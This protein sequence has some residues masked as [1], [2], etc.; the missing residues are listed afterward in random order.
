MIRHAATVLVLRPGADGREVYMVRRS[1]KSPF[2]PST[3]VF[4]GGRVDPEDGAIDQDPS[5]ERAARRECEEEARLRLGPDRTL[6]WFD[7]WLTPS[8]ESRRRYLARFF[9]TELSVGE[10]TEA[11]ADG[12]ETHEGRWA[13]AAEHLAAWETEEVDLPPPT[14]AMLL[15]LREAERHGLPAMLDVDPRALI[16]PKVI[17]ADGRLTILMPHDPDYAV[18]PGE[19]AP[20]P[21]R[22]HGLP[23]R[24]V[25]DGQRWR[26]C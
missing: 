19:A 13:T 10:G 25:R 2:M 9:M 1:A 4:P 26:P 20:A 22:V 14:L 18:A 3:L 8:A 16:L 12:V 7:T 6:R 23:S 5:W 11:Q 21:A 17:I 15:R 24:F